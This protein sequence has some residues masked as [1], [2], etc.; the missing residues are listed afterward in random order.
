MSEKKLTIE[1][2]FAKLEETAAR[3]ESGE[4]SLEESF[5]LYEAGMKLLKEASDRI[6]LVEKKMQVIGEAGVFPPDP[7]GE[8]E[9]AP[10]F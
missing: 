7:Q 6:D 5:A 10:P 9:E 2:I 8:E 4:V 1:E 3:L